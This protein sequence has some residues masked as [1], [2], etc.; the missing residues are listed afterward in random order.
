M[1]VSISNSAL[2]D[3]ENMTSYYTEEGIPQ[4]GLKFAKEIIK[5]IQ[6][7]ADHPDM[8]RIVPELQLP[9]IREMIVA[10]FRVVYLRE[11]SA[12]KVIRVWR[13]ER[14]LVLPVE[15]EGQC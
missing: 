10:P 3:L 5:H 2:K 7:L 8:G 9:H 1:K 14:P 15:T 4:I 13:S 11:E 6:M 12:I